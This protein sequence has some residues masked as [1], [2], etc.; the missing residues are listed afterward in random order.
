MTTTTS[1]AA[2]TAREKSDSPASNSGKAASP[3][4]Q[5]SRLSSGSPASDYDQSNAQWQQQPK[6][7]QKSHEQQQQQ[8]THQSHERA[9][10]SR[11]RGR[12]VK[13]DFYSEVTVVRPAS[14]VASASSSSTTTLYP[15]INV[16]ST[17]HSARLSSLSTGA[18]RDSSARSP[19]ETPLQHPLIK[20]RDHFLQ[21]SMM[22]AGGGDSSLQS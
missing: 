6:Q 18:G 4:I 8:H 17:G 12:P 7:Q 2:A 21:E 16:M 10:H 19:P 20:V 22:R 11:S 9:P 1:T 14:N 5:H 13:A 15:E 3:R